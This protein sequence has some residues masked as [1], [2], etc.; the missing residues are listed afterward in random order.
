MRWVCVGISLSAVR[1]SSYLSEWI[2]S[3][4]SSSGNEERCLWKDRIY[5]HSFMCMVLFFMYSSWPL[6]PL[7]PCAPGSPGN[8]G[9]P[10][11]PLFPG[12][13]S[14]PGK[15]TVPAVHKKITQKHH[16]YTPHMLWIRCISY[17]SQTCV[18]ASHF[19]L[20]FIQI[21]GLLSYSLHFIHCDIFYSWIT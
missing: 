1:R 19:A 9:I 12:V 5:I 14:T 8:P 15:P 4:S 20:K 2:K 18:C 3:S 11:V 7:F 13:P 17:S 21:I 16:N 10:S 6:L